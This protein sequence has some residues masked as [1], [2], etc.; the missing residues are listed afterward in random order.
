M[1]LVEISL[2][3]SRVR[4]VPVGLAAEF[5]ARTTTSA[6]SAPIIVTHMLRVRTIRV[7]SLV[8]AT[9]VGRDREWCAAATTN[10]L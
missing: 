9:L 8:R 10:A 4:A 7:H 3:H 6:R 2:A 1:L 5:Y